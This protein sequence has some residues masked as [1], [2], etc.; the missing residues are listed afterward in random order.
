M[1]QFKVVDNHLEDEHVPSLRDRAHVD[2]V[3]DL[4]VAGALGAADVGEL[5]LEVV[6][7]VLHAV[8]GDLELEGTGEGGGVVEHHH[9][10]DLNLRHG[11]GSSG[12]AP[13]N[14]TL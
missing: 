3:E 6:L 12:I 13:R 1:L 2:G 7:Q 10:V 11:D 4:V 9:V 8:E 14:A 5:P